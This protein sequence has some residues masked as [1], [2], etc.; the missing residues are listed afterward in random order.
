MEVLPMYIVHRE[1]APRH[2]TSTGSSRTSS[3][4]YSPLSVSPHLSPKGP[5]YTSPGYSPAGS[6]LTPVYTLP[7]TPIDSNYFDSYEYEPRRKTNNEEDVHVTKQVR[8]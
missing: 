6:A 1:N 8:D 4:N 3:H 2:N 5:G 7:M